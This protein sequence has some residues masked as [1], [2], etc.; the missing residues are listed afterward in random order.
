MQCSAR[1][2]RERNETKTGMMFQE[3]NEI[4]GITMLIIISL[5]DAGVIVSNMDFS[6]SF[7]EEINYIPGIIHQLEARNIRSA[8][9]IE[10]DRCHWTV[11]ESDSRLQALW[12]PRRI[13]RVGRIRHL[14]CPVLDVE[15]DFVNGI[16]SH[17]QGSRHFNF[18]GD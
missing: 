14:D 15:S 9:R 17:R 3:N 18:I 4:S 8:S 16:S 5:V 7:N 13:F 1:D 11:S 10:S 2:V 12:C 6:R